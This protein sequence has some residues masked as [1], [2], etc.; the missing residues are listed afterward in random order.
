MTHNLV[1]SIDGDAA[2][3]YSSIEICMIENGQSMIAS[4]YYVDILR[5][6][7]GEWE[8]VVRDN[9]SYHLVPHLKGWAAPDEAK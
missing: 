5:R 6:V 7:N 1:I 2:S 4:G 8:F 3:A 9:T